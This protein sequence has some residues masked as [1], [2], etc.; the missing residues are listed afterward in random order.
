[1]NKLKH[2]ANIIGEEYGIPP[3]DYFMETRKREFTEPRQV[4]YYIARETTGFS[5]SRLAD[6]AASFGRSKPHSHCTVLHSVKLVEGAIAI[7]PE[8]RHRVF[9]LITKTKDFRSIIPDHIDLIH[10]TITGGN[11]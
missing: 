8:Y 2:I 9:N 4:F 10:L 5:F 1:M 7:Y 11:V 6:F 3:S